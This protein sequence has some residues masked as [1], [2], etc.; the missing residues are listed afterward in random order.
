MTTDISQKIFSVSI[1]SFQNLQSG[2]AN[3]NKEECAKHNK[4]DFFLWHSLLKNA[5][6]TRFFQYHRFSP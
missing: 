1:V 5:L 4:L 2:K 6:W 3:A